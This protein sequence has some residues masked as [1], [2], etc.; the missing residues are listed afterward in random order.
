MARGWAN[1]L[2]A[3][4]IEAR[5]AG[6]D[7]RGSSPQAIA[8]MQEA[9]IDILRQESVRLSH[10][11][12]RWADLVVTVCGHAH[13]HCPVLPP[14]VLRRHWALA[15]PSAAGEDAE[16]IMPA[17][18]AAR[19]DIRHRVGNLIVELCSNRRALARGA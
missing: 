13:Q 5:S 12:L 8:V 10:E 14:G 15:D 19:D 1:H 2:G 18:R 16:A 9:G 7:A 6:F 11:T 4:Y 17:Y 3:G